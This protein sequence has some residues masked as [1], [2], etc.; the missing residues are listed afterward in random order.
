MVA[1]TWTD[2]AIVD[3]SHRSL[4]INRERRWG[5]L[6]GIVGCRSTSGRSWNCGS[7]GWSSSGS[8]IPQLA[9]WSKK[10]VDAGNSEL[11][12]LRFIVGRWMILASVL[13]SVLV[14]VL[15]SM[16]C[17]VMLGQYVLLTVV[18]YWWL[19]PTGQPVIASN[20]SVGRWWIWRIVHGPELMSTKIVTTLKY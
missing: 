13:A 4:H 5:I 7:W 11:H 8:T 20:W 16:F 15:A 14:S 17:F 12:L 2:K 3:D 10:H 18:D 6:G 9:L 1:R 19:W